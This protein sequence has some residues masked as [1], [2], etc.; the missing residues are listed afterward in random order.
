MISTKNSHLVF[1]VKSDSIPAIAQIKEILESQ[2][3]IWDEFSVELPVSLLEEL[4]ANAVEQ[5]FVK[6]CVNAEL[7][8]TSLDEKG[9]RR[10]LTERQLIQILRTGSFSVP[11][12][13][14]PSQSHVWQLNSLFLQFGFE[15]IHKFSQSAFVASLNQLFYWKEKLVGT[16]FPSFYCSLKSILSNLLEIPRLLIG[17]KELKPRYDSI[18]LNALSMQHA[19]KYLVRN[20]SQIIKHTYCNAD[21]TINLDFRLEQ[22]LK[23][24][25]VLILLQTIETKQKQ[26]WALDRIEFRHAEQQQ[27]LFQQLAES[28]SIDKAWEQMYELEAFE[29][30]RRLIEKFKSDPELR[31]ICDELGGLVAAHLKSIEL[32]KIAQKKSR[33]EERAFQSK[34]EIELEKTH[35]HQLRVANWKAEIIDEKMS[36]FH[37]ARKKQRS[38]YYGDLLA[39]AKQ[40]NLG[41]EVFQLTRYIKFREKVEKPLINTLTKTIDPALQ[42]TWSKEIWSPRNW[43]LTPFYE[44]VAANKMNYHVEKGVTMRSDSNIY[45]WRLFSI[46]QDINVR[47]NNT[48]YTVYRNAVHGKFGL[49]ALFYPRPFHPE[50][51]VTSEGKVV[52]DP[53]VAIETFLSRVKTI[54]LAVKSARRIFE[55]TTP[56]A[57]SFSRFLNIT[58]NYF[59]KG[60]LPTAVVTLVFPPVSLLYQCF[61][62]VLGITSFAWIP[63]AA[64][65]RYLFR[66]SIYDSVT[67]QFI[68]LI[69]ILFRI[70]LYGLPQLAYSSA[71]IVFHPVLA[72]LLIVGSW[73][74]MSAMKV[75]DAIMLPVI[76]SRVRV[77]HSNSFY[78]WRSKGPEIDGS[79]YYRVPFQFGLLVIQEYLERLEISHIRDRTLL[80]IDAPRL[81]Y[82]QLFKELFENFG[83]TLNK[84]GSYDNVV[85]KC[86]QFK[87]EL[88][89]KVEKRNNEE[90]FSPNILR[91][92]L[93]DRI[94]FSDGEVKHVLIQ[95]KQLIESFYHSHLEKY[96]S[97]TDTLEFW[98]RRNLAR[99]D[100]EGLARTILKDRLGSKW[101]AA[102]NDANPYVVNVEPTQFVDCSK[103][104]IAGIEFNANQYIDQISNVPLPTWPVVSVYDLT[105]TSGNFLQLLRT[106]FAE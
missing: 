104:V 46:L 9:A 39:A 32:V 78:M 31:K 77:P 64:L 92:R 97:E 36:D 89:A 17:F 67:K 41:A 7:H 47:L 8:N 73:L 57:S 55:Q 93:Q 24:P 33:D 65:L 99:N 72:V 25:N 18:E 88:L 16:T 37:C 59:F 56:E 75:H 35:K 74:I 82:E 84:T 38:V 79:V 28:V 10:E 54:W 13:F 96:L 48:F 95:G 52:A 21:D 12:P 23:N 98:S 63:S 85:K 94:I 58:W 86:D 87:A 3:Y 15:N 105:L 29:G 14:F 69:R 5:G 106:K 62:I 4:P 83:F 43:I 68:P 6:Y 45:G 80:E 11:S 103:K 91:L 40:N 26:Q 2:L 70:F 19:K 22:Y 60:I 66:I 100:W 27:K 30:N 50:C 61:N 81:K 49:K 34:F 1:E 76:R 42:E 44:D 20:L 90:K 51:C 53:A 71:A 101:L 102:G